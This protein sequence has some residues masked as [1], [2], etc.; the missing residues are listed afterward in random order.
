MNRQNS[1][2]AQ[3]SAEER[4]KYFSIR[5][6]CRWDL[7]FLCREILGYPDVNDEVHGTLISRLQQFP[8]PNGIHFYNNDRI[9]QGRIFYTPIE[10]NPL[11][12]PGKRRFLILD[13]R[14][15]LKTTINAQAH[16][17]QWILNYPD[18]AMLIVQSNTEKAEMILGEIKAHFQA[19][20]KFR[21][22]FPDHCPTRRIFD[23]GTKGDFTT[24]ARS[25][26]CTRKE[27]TLM[28]G[29]IDKGSAGLHFDVQKFSDIVEPNNSSSP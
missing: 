8:R 2:L 26:S 1:G 15:H 4:D 25:R 7:G 14:G 19:N 22:F 21:A 3:M 10:P 24:E 27:P 5:W 13:A 17:I 9:E 11:K 6:R 12:L 28:C 16:T 20:P 18:I 29:S 23:W